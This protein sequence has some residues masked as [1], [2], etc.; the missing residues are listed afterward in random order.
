MRI[1]ID[2]SIWSKAFRRKKITSEDKNI[3]DRLKQVI[4]EFMEIIIGPIRQELLSGITLKYLL[5][6]MISSNTRSIYP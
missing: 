3:V 6:I 2:T 5:R 4:N 1:L